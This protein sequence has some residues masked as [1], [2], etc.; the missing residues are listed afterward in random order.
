MHG[1]KIVKTEANKSNLICIFERN[2]NAKIISDMDGT[3]V[4]IVFFRY[5]K[6]LQNQ[7]LVRRMGITN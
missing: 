4:R 2:I 5:H 3:F 6:P 1:N 7:G